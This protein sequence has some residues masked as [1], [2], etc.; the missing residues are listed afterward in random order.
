MRQMSEETRIAEV[1]ERLADTYAELPF[2]Q[3]A[4]VVNEALAHFSAAP[5]REFVPLLVERR[6]RTELANKDSVLALSA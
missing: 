4:S 5:L 1:V 3:V 2:E 6:A